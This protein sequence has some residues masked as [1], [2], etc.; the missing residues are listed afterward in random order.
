LWRRR[1]AK[2]VGTGV[3]DC[4]GAGQRAEP[5]PPETTIANPWATD[6]NDVLNVVLEKFHEANQLKSIDTPGEDAMRGQTTQSASGRSGGRK[7]GHQ[8][9]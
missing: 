8:Q 5:D 9:G 3:A 6:D 7:P 1:V 2:P 4:C